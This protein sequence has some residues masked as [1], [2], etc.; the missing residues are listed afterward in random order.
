MQW[1]VDGGDDPGR[2]PR[3]RRHR[4]RAHARDARGRCRRQRHR[5][6]RRHRPRRRHR[7]RSTTRPPRP[8]SG[9]R[10]HYTVPSRA[11]T[12]PAPASTRS[13]VKIDGGAVSRTRTSPSPA[14]ACTRCSTRI[15]DNVGH[16]SAW[17]ER[18]DQHR[19]RR[20]DGDPLLPRRG[21]HDPRGRPARRPPTAGRPASARSPPRTTAARTPRS[22]RRV[23][24]VS[25]NGTHT[26]TLTAADGA[27]NIE[28][29][30]GDRQVDRTAPTAALTCAAAAAPT[31]YACRAERIRRH[32]RPGRALATA[33]TA[34]PG[35]RSRRAV[36]SRSPRARCGSARSTPPATRPSRPCHAG[37]SHASASAPAGRHAAS[38]V[39]ARLP[40]RPRRRRQHDRRAEGGAQRQ[41]HRVG[42][43]P[44]ARRRSRHAT[45]SRSC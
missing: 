9:A 13:S 34:A 42:R 31:G 44:A 25:A 21:G 19:R 22:R 16:A 33:S 5:L 4:R 2:R 43:P 1:R 30:A 10:P 3:D 38:R 28:R 18:D 27:G 8:P 17:R 29:S 23:V 39:R 32:V 12:A 11:P 36:R 40:R 45:R 7:R 20:P 6:A 15:V 14:T 24:P 41:R 37:R 26:I 35:R